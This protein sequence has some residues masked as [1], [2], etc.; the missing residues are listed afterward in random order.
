MRSMKG[1]PTTA[2]YVL[3]GTEQKNAL[4]DFAAM[5]ERSL[6]WI[7][8]KLIKDHVPKNPKKRVADPDPDP[9]ADVDLKDVFSIQTKEEA[10]IA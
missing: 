3:I 4:V 10:G 6:R 5:E 7:V 9:F 8:E 2:L 1:K